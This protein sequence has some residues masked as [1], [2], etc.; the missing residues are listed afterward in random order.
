M[1]IYSAILRQMPELKNPTIV[2]QVDRGESDEFDHL[3]P[4]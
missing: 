3:N 2:V 4:E 1:A